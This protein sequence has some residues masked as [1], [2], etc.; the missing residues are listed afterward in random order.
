[1]VTKAEFPNSRAVWRNKFGFKSSTGL[2]K[3]GKI[4]DRE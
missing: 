2:I 4:I 3:Y 1:M